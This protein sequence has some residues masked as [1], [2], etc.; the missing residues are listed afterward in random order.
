MS[1]Y[2]TD[3]R[4]ISMPTHFNT[5]FISFRD[6]FMGMP[7]IKVNKKLF[8]LIVLPKTLVEYKSKHNT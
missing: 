2:P 5:L 4:K 8:T 7:Q 6:T 1:I 3:F